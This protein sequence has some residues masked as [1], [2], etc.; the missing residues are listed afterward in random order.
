VGESSLIQADI[1]LR[2]AA[3]SS[4]RS[5]NQV[6]S[7]DLQVRFFILLRFQGK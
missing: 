5:R 3:S 6:E 7:Y 4:V 2:E 1:N